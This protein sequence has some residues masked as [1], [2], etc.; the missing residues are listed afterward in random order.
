MKRRVAPSLGPPRSIAPAGLSVGP[1]WS[2]A[3]DT[4]QVHRGLALFGG[5]LLSHGKVWG[6]DMLLTAEHLRSQ[7]CARALNYLEVYNIERETVYDIADDFPGTF[8]RL[9]MH[10]CKLAL[11]RMIVLMTREKPHLLELRR[12]YPDTLGKLLDRL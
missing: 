7:N 11:R 12:R 9:R 10:V 6:E 8:K 4:T 2:V 1:C 5:R 3:S